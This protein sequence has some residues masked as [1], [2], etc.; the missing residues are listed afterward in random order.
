MRSSLL[1][2]LASTLLIAANKNDERL[3]EASEVLR[4]V[5]AAP[6]KA[7][8]KELLNKSRCVA[9]IPGFKKGAFVIGVSYGKGYVSCRQPGKSSW[10]APATILLQGGSI[11]A[12]LGGTESDLILL[13][14]NQ[15]GADSLLQSK[16]TL[17]G[18]IQAAAG[19]VGR[20][21]TAETDAAMRAEI[22]SYSRARGLF[23]GI[24]LQGATFRADLD[25]NE[26]LY[27]RRLTTAD[28]VKERKAKPTASGQKFINTLTRFSPKA[29]Q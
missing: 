26:A 2:C 25:S 10:S 8:P 20:S 1:L 9:V 15:R 14:M 16:F 19:P 23:A 18:A 28:I 11:G 21:S 13:V 4:E 24:S 17:G 7:I 6:D 5:M 12:Q 22:L 29:I 27:K 3:T